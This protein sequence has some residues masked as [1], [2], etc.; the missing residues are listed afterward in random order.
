MI[1]PKCG[2]IIDALQCDCGCDWITNSI[3]IIGN[4]IQDQLS[5]LSEA[6]EQTEEHSIND[7][8][9]CL[10]AEIGY[11]HDALENYKNSKDDYPTT[12]NEIETT[13]KK[14]TEKIAD[15]RNA[16]TESGWKGTV[17]SSEIHNNL[18]G[19]IEKGE[20]YLKDLS[21]TFQK[22]KMECE[23]DS[24][25]ADY[26]LFLKDYKQDVD[27]LGNKTTSFVELN[28]YL[29][30]VKRKGNQCKDDV[31][32]AIRM[33]INYEDKEKG[34][35]SWQYNGILREMR[36]K[37]DSLS[38]KFESTTAL[39]EGIIFEKAVKC[40]Q[41]GHINDGVKYIAKTADDGYALAQREL[42][43]IYYLGK[44]TQ[45]N[46]TEAFKW[47]L[48]A[49]SQGDIYAILKVA[50]MFKNGQGIRKNQ[51]RAY[52]WSMIAANKG[53]DEGQYRVGQHYYTGEG[54]KQ[55]YDEALKW[56]VLA[57]NQGNEAASFDIGK[58]YEEGKGVKQNTILAIKW[59]KHAAGKGWEIAQNKYKSLLKEDMESRIGRRISEG[60]TAKQLEEFDSFTDLSSATKWLE[61]NRPDYR[62][63]V[64]EERQRIVKEF[65][66][67]YYDL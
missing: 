32:N 29:A 28:T 4:D 16:I 50:D 23:I 12:L 65:G 64:E 45:Q 42:G 26:E 53:N 35:L 54:V 5:Y 49:A 60:L 67:D 34:H 19:L 31:S 39:L 40:I 30:E 43:N 2:N 25:I 33:L 55:N 59:Y 13:C 47:Y 61:I 41:E 66:I 56:F 7:E 58:M 52:E 1:C 17:H 57:A 22:K 10:K 15:A 44:H 21:Y 24:K 38:N 6:R 9:I 27:L 36:G 8:V 48:A 63:I 18:E 46:Y 51:L 11:V 37:S 14:L 62:N 20:E 3:C